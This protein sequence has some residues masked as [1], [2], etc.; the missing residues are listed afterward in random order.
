MKIL[1]QGKIKNI[2]G[3]KRFKCNYCGCVFEAEQGEY[4]SG[5]HYN[6]TYYFCECPFCGK[7]APEVVMRRVDYALE[8]EF[9]R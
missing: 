3:I 5:Q 4:K 6:D 9:N 2:S 8:Q 1:K 7:Q